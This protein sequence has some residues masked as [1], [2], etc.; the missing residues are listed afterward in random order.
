MALR[1]ELVLGQATNCSAG[2]IQHSLFLVKQPRMQLEGDDRK[3]QN[4][5]DIEIHWGSFVVVV[6]R[7]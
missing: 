7:A 2:D 5:E 3:I 4:D 1:Q 6:W